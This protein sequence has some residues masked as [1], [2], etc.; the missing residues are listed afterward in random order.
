VTSVK[1]SS[2]APFKVTPWSERVP[3]ITG[4]A[5]VKAEIDTYDTA[6][7]RRQY[8]QQVIYENTRD[9]SQA[10]TTAQK[11]VIQA[12]LDVAK[13][14]LA[15]ADGHVK[16]AEDNIKKAR[17]A[18]LVADDPSNAVDLIKAG[19]T[20]SKKLADRKG[21]I[22][23]LLKE[24]ATQAEIDTIFATPNPRTIVSVF[25]SRREADSSIK[26]LLSSTD[27]ELLKIF[28][29]SGGFRQRTYRRKKSIKHKTP[30][31][32]KLKPVLGLP[33][34]PKRNRTYRISKKGSKRTPRRSS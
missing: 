17:K 12:R 19:Y 18:V 26:E 31:Q 8:T 30:R 34:T 27:A 13:Q 11:K 10:K 25:Q 23:I 9:L 20:I 7:K 28:R 6:I 32:L 14:D 5:D 3:F 1:Q 22:Y 21:D 15:E 24:T 4:Q 29:S 2:D 33:Y 16:L